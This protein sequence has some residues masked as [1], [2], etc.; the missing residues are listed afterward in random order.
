MLLLAALDGD[1]QPPPPG[2]SG[3]PNRVCILRAVVFADSLSE[4]RSTLAPLTEHPLLDQA[5]F[6]Q[7]FQPTTID[8]LQLASVDYRS[9]F[10]FGRYLVDSNFTAEPIT[11]VKV[12]AEQFAQAPGH[13]SHC[14]VIFKN[15]PRLPEDAA[16]SVMGPCWMGRY[17][18]WQDPA[19]DPAVL[20][21][22]RDS[23]TAL[24][25]VS[26]GRYINE[27]DV[28]GG[29]ERISSCFSAD[30][31]KRLRGL[32]AERDPRELFADY[33]GLI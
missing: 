25:P 33:Q 23:A 8:Q 17:G 29:E 27:I 5:L 9:Q 18:V 16:C 30:S 10:G 6:K 22:I 13:H 24:M 19:E 31:W 28:R 7:E 11:A 21:W 15:R 32:K 1:R 26:Q 14:V 3:E 20:E 4:A 2:E 12:L